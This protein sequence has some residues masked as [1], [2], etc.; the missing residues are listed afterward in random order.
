[1][2]IIWRERCLLLKLITLMK[3]DNFIRLT[4]NNNDLRD[5]DLVGK[6]RCDKMSNIN[7]LG[8]FSSFIRHLMIAAWTI[9]GFCALRSVQKFA[10]LFIFINTY[11]FFFIIRHDYTTFGLKQRFELIIVIQEIW[12]YLWIVFFFTQ[13]IISLLM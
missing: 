3:F 9:L 6:S 4:L 2:R 5:T 8:C 13:W 1:M 10:N 12:I 11:W 7:S